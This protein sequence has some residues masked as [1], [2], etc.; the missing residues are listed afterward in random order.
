MLFHFICLQDNIVHDFELATLFESTKSKAQKKAEKKEIKAQE[1]ETV[2][3]QE[4]KKTK[5]AL[6]GVD[7]TWPFSLFPTFKA[8]RIVTSHLCFLPLTNII[9]FTLVMV[10]EYQW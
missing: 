7:Y 2:T 6:I 4:D 9:R 3:E 8:L 10:Q 5:W 1:N